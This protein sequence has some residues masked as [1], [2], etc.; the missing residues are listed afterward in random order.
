MIDKEKIKEGVKFILEGLGEDLTREGLVRT[1]DRVAKLFSNI[2]IGYGPKPEITRFRNSKGIDDILVRKCDFLSFCE[3]HVVPYSGI[4][5][6]AY[7]PGEWLIG[8]N[9]IDRVVD[10]FAGR[11]QL[12][13]HMTHDIA[14]FLMDS[15]SPKGV[16]VQSYAV[17]YCALCYKDSGSFG[18]AAVRGLFKESWDLELKAMEI[19]KR[20]DNL[21]LGGGQ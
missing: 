7:I 21:S 10:Y 19:F 8:L 5:Y 14:N 16:V 9:K 18:D 20:L 2:F 1:P 3:H 15:F 17:H 11:L 12:Q 6:V 4:V 13:E